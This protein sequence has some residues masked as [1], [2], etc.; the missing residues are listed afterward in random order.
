MP[1]H[2]LVIDQSTA[3]SRALVF[4]AAQNVVGE[5]KM[6][7]TQHQ[8]QLHHVEQVP[9]EIW[10]TC[11][12]ACKTALR[13]AGITAGDLAGIAIANQRATS[14][15]WDRATGRAIYNAIV[16]RDQRTAAACEDLI[17][18]GKEGLVRARTGLLIHPYFSALKIGWLLDNVE[19]ARDRALAGELAFGTIDS[20]LVWRLTGGKVHATDATNAAQ[21]TLFNIETNCW[22]PDLLDLFGVPAQLLPEVKDS[23]DD[24][25]ASE[26]DILDAPVPILGVI[27]NQQAALIG[28]ACFAPG[29][30]K[31]T[32]DEHCFAMLNTGS[33]I[34]RSGHRLLTTIAYRLRGKSTYALEGAIVSVGG[35]L[36]WLHDD[37]ELIENWNQLDRMAAASD[38]TLPIYMVPAFIG[39]GSNWQEAE[40]RGALFGLS[41]GTRPHDLVRAALEA[42]GYQSHDLFNTMRH[43]WG[44][45]G[46]VIVRADGD[47]TASDWNMQ[48]LADI[49]DLVVVR[50][51]S[52]DIIPTGAA[53]LA[54]QKLGL[55]P[56]QAGFAERRAKNRE[57]HPRMAEEV[58]GEKLAG[59]R[60]ATARVVPGR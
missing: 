41:R 12:W 59:W 17:D 16:W 10:A 7:I 50:T 57:F 43:D 14:V 4:D 15:V 30:L 52:S 8:P 24:Y 51:S 37:L 27:G 22:D 60:D 5:G 3:S 42:V 13:R 31:A 35:S 11:L 20:F 58:R 1:T 55:W 48:F 19:G 28:H 47:V 56:D 36:Q 39:G 53:W 54:G 38:P 23:A 29:M 33:D 21:T 44:N 46:D 25:G 32:Y 49:T 45:G 40:A 34:V 26:A 6:D 2:I 9:E 18:A